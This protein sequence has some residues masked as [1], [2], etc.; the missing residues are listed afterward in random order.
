LRGKI[1]LGLLLALLVEASS[2]HAILGGFS[3]AYVL[4]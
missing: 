4:L 3:S 1:A 2:E